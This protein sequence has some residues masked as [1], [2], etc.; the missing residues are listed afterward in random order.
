MAAAGEAIGS[1]D[2][3]RV[4]DSSRVGGVVATP[5]PGD[6]ILFYN[7]GADGEVDRHAIHAACEVTGGVKWAANHWFTLPEEDAGGT[8]DEL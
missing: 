3:R 4:C 5:T 6:A 2:V 7:F 1:G 8:R